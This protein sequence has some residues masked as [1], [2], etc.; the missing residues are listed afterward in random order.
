[1]IVLDG[2]NDAIVGQASDWTGSESVDKLVY[3][4]WKMVDVLIEKDGMTAD[5]AVEFVEYNCVGTKVGKETPI[6]YWRI[7]DIEELDI[8]KI[9]EPE[10][11]KDGRVH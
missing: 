6:I 9:E 2:F 5:E 3:D 7:D 1:M 10:E 11:I 4:G 8:Q